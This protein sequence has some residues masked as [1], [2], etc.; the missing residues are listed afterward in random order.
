MYVDQF[1]LDQLI[2]RPSELEKLHLKK[3]MLTVLLND[4]RMGDAATNSI[5]FTKQGDLK[6]KKRKALKT[7]LWTRP[8]NPPAD[9]VQIGG[10][11][12]E[13]V[14]NI[15]HGLIAQ[16]EVGDHSYERADFLTF[17]EQRHLNEMPLATC[18]HYR[19]NLKARIMIMRHLQRL[20]HSKYAKPLMGQLAMY[21]ENAI[22]SS[23]VRANSVELYDQLVN[24]ATLL[25]EETG[26]LLPMYHKILFNDV[27]YAAIVQA[28][29]DLAAVPGFSQTKRVEVWRS[30]HHFSA[31]QWLNRVKKAVDLKTLI[32]GFDC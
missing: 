13:T 29:T 15:T 4:G 3:T 17:E 31:I 22:D 5:W 18:E 7:V 14:C 28:S 16:F 12:M 10:H 21:A 25:M 23:A 32:A 27:A 6:T 11:S 8:D 30:T 24:A 9:V 19:A 2:N 26:I 20:L 1:V